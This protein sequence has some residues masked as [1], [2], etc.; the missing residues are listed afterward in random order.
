MNDYESM[1]RLARS[2]LEA[3][4]SNEEILRACYGV[5]FPA[6]ALVFAELILDERAPDV[7]CM[8]LPWE[9]LTPL[10]TGGPPSER[11]SWDRKPPRLAQLDPSLVALV[12]LY[13]DHT[14]GGNLICYRL[15]EL[16]AGRST[17]FGIPDD[18]PDDVVAE[19]L[20]DSLGIVLHQY[21]ED[22]VRTREWES[23]RDRTIG[24]D[25][26]EAAE[27]QL[28]RVE[29]LILMTTE[30]LAGQT[31]PK[32]WVRR[33]LN[34]ELHAAA[35][36]DDVPALRDL[37][38]RGA[39][40][41]PR[42]RES[43]LM[44]AIGKSQLNAARFLLDA[45]SDLDHG[46]DR[47]GPASRACRYATLPMIEFVLERGASLQD[48]QVLSYATSN[49][50][51]ASV[52]RIM[53]LLVKYGI[54]PNA[55]T[56]AES[57]LMI[58]CANG[59]LETV[60]ELLDRGADP[61]MRRNG[62]ALTVAEENGHEVIVDLLL[63]RGAVPDRP[64]I[65]EDRE[66]D[67][68]GRAALDQPGDARRRLAWAEVLLRRGFLAAAAREAE[69]A[70]KLDPSSS[71]AGLNFENPPG[72]TWAFAPFEATEVAA[73]I[74]D[75]RFPSARV[76]SGTR[77]LP[78]SVVLGPA[79]TH[80]D[81]K[82]ETSC[83]ECNGTG[84]ADNWLTGGVHKC[85]PR[86]TCERC[87]GLKYVVRSRAFGKGRCQ[88]EVMAPEFALPPRQRF[89]S[90]YELTLNRCVECGLPAIDDEL[91]CGL[92]GFLDCRCTRSRP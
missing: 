3:G 45:G 39:E 24:N 17:V 6:E 29:D 55:H 38:A 12:R 23:S 75:S 9:L 33:S 85:E 64:A 26:V 65:P 59:A 27:E 83:T 42:G 44:G 51:K 58:A 47:F 31:R 79:C 19:R 46:G 53:G 60:R 67:A 82:G 73:Q 88:H 32:P 78:L 7:D 30:R 35:E 37:L 2:M 49:P 8:S 22:V 56:H 77:T 4:K 90:R 57:V 68:I 43:A 14:H 69:S 76:V 40:L 34:D 50:D 61:N 1:A 84:T 25:D 92:C 80:C 91:A 54:D 13:G 66:G 10:E 71:L 41:E 74:E 62:T 87:W 28:G 86:Q 11:P 48:W 20:G 5:S 52:G 18:L 89:G 21:F 15:D 63:E 36:R 81:E 72:T 16:A 70:A